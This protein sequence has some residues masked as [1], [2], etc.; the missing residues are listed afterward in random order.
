MAGVS[1]LEQ[2]PL[3]LHEADPGCSD[4]HASFQALAVAE[5]GRAAN[6]IPNLPG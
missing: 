5:V 2:G 3:P 4:G 6:G 1:D